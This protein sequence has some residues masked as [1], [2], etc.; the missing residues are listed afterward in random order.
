MS[1][2]EIEFWFDFA[3]PYSYPSAMVIEDRAAALAY[4]SFFS[5]FSLFEH[6]HSSERTSSSSFIILTHSNTNARTNK[7]S[8]KQTLE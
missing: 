1:R 2:G 6:L 5:L 8:N 4:F 7:R 3:S